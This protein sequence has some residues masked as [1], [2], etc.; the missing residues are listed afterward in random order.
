MLASAASR[1]SGTVLFRKMHNKPYVPLVF[2]PLIPVSICKTKTFLPPFLLSFLSKITYKNHVIQDLQKKSR[3][4]KT[5]E[6]K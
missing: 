6:E 1:H 5:T 2:S 4:A 3:S